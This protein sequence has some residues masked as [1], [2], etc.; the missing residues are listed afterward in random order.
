[1]QRGRLV[2]ILIAL[3]SFLLPVCFVYWSTIF[4]EIF[5]RWHVFPWW[6]Y[7]SWSNTLELV[8]PWQNGYWASFGLLWTVPVLYTMTAIILIVNNEFSFRK[9]NRWAAGLSLVIVVLVIQ[10]VWPIL[11]FLVFVDQWVGVWFF[12]PLPVSSLV[13]LIGLAWVFAERW[14]ST[15]L[16]PKSAG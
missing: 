9:R 10:T 14:R 3:S 6:I 5:G 2:S 4:L 8:T 1:V 12:V 16:I 7:D 11:V 15:V 13:A